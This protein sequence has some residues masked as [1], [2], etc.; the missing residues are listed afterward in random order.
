MITRRFVLSGAGLLVLAPAISAC[1][2]VRLDVPVDSVIVTEEALA[3]VNTLRA[4]TGLVPL[5][6]DARASAA[7]RRQAENMARRGRMTHSG[8]RGRMRGAGVS[9]PAAE[10]IAM[11][12]P[13]TASAVE[14]WASSSGHRRNMLG[15]YG[16]VGVAYARRD[17]GRPYWAMVLSGQ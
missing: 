8:F 13:D 7:A 9:F 6:S 4:N 3:Y 14:S 10:N 5:E 11:G 15:D 12:Q 1:N 16:R 2:S 17:G